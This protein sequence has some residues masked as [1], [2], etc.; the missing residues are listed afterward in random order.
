MFRWR[1]EEVLSERF[2]T[3]VRVAGVEAFPHYA[4]VSRCTLEVAGGTDAVPRSV[5]VRVARDR[6]D[7]PARSGVAR[8]RNEQAALEFLRAIGSDLAPRCIAGDA[9]AGFLVSEDL[10]TGPSPLDLLLGDDA[11]IARQ[12]LLAFARGLGTLHAQTA[13]RAA[14]Y[15]ARRAQ[16]GPADADPQ[17][18][19]AGA[20]ARGRVEASWRRVQDVAAQLGLPNPGGVDGDVAEVERTLAAPDAYLALSSG[21]PSPVNCKVVEGAVRFFDFEA[22]G[23]RHVLVDA[24]VLRYLYPTGGPAWRVPEDVTVAMEAAYREE[25]ARGCPDALDDADYERGMAAACAAWTI[26][27][28]VRLPLVES[29]PDKNAWPLVPPGWWGPLPTRSRRRQLVAT[30]ET[31]VASARRAGTLDALAAW[32]ERLAGALRARWPEAAEGLPLYRAFE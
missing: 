30:V 31:C 29:G 8:L 28:L 14:E 23:F 10:G 25:L 1:V 3:R 4:H 21:D 6:R 11:E 15:D 9:G 24:T 22:A 16:L 32:C 5:I 2:G 19:F 27:R 26:V 18:V 17:G 13:G 12:G 7:D 20:W